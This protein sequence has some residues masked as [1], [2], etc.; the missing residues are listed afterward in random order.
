MLLAMA[1]APSETI[2]VYLSGHIHSDWRQSLRRSAAQR[3]LPVRFTGPVEDHDLS[4]NVGLELLKIEKD[5]AGAHHATLR[6][7]LGG[8]INMLRSRVHLMAADLV[9][10]FYD[11]KHGNLRQW[12]PAADL[13]IAAQAG[14]PV[15]LVADRNL[16][17]ALK[18]LRQQACV[19]IH[20]LEQAVAL[21]SYL[22]TGKLD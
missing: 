16:G 15:V 20:T 12:S 9:L 10:V 2:T 14:K 21:L 8:S 7:E 1:D 13:A 6:D 3:R 22:T 5:Y 18:E 11:A 17:H 19:W 4:D